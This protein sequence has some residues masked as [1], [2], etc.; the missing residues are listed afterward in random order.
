MAVQRL[1]ADTSIQWVALTVSDLERSLN[2]YTE[3]LGLSH[4]SWLDDKVVLGV[5]E[6][7][8]LIILREKKGAIPKPA[9]RRGLYHY[10]LL[11][12]TR[13]DL[14]RLF[15]RLAE[16]WQFE[17]ASDHLVSEALYIQ[18]PDGHGVE[19]YADRPR[20]GWRWT[21]SYTLQMATLPLNI[22]SLLYE[23]RGEG[24]RVAV[25]SGWRIPQNSRLGHI[26]LHVSRLEKAERFYHGVLGFD[27]TFRLSNSAL[28][29]SAGKYHHH[30]GVNTWAGID[31][32]PPSEEHVRLESFAI[33][34]GGQTVIS[35]VRARLLEAGFEI[36]DR[37]V[38]NID[39]FTGFTVADLD[40]NLVEL[41][42]VKR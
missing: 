22:N 18:D 11:M 37:L 23:L 7:G 20:D 41:V 34:L 8:P 28:F 4:L 39:G 30:I 38:N 40:G 36:N 10:A 25:S 21:S 26:H 13:T 35:E 15:V 29:M 5:E 19:I 14:A 27:I 12:P 24:K 3:I 42:T 1:G 32:P 33:K 16:Y 9:D 17:G 2:F 6:S 31:A